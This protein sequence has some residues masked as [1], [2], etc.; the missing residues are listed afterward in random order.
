MSWSILDLIRN[1]PD[2]LKDNL[3]RRFIDVSIVD[4][5]VELDRKWRQKLNEINKLRH[6]HNKL[7][8]EVSRAPKIRDKRR[9]KRR[10]NS[11]KSSN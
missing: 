3:K 11:L 4:R 6:E 10:R 2:K 7:S 9:S 5:I 8:Q 1:S